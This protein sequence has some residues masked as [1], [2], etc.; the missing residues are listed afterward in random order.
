MTHAVKAQ[1]SPHQDYIHPRAA[2][3]HI[4]MGECDDLALSLMVSERQKKIPSNPAASVVIH[5]KWS[6]ISWWTSSPARSSQ[7]DWNMSG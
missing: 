2:F 1:A 3:K 5:T 7:L 6:T 4:Q